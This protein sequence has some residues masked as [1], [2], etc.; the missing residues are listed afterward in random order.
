M[1]FRGRCPFKM[2]LPS[3]P[4]KY[5]IKIILICDN[6]TKY[7]FNADVYLG[8]GHHN[9]DRT[10][11]L[12]QHFT[13]KLISPLMNSNRN[14]TCDNWFSSVELAETLLDYKITM[15]GT[16]RKNK[17]YFPDEFTNPLY[18]RR[19]PGSSMFLFSEK[20]TAVS[21][22]PN[23]K[24]KVV[25]LIST[26][27][28]DDSINS[29]SGKPEIILNYNDAKG[30][31]DTFDQLC[32]NMNCG[33][34]TR[35]WPMCFF[36]NLINMALHNAYVIYVHNHYKNNKEIKALSRFDF[37]MQLADELSS[38]W[39]HLRLSQQIPRSLKLTISKCLKIDSEIVPEKNTIFGQRR[40]CF[41]CPYKKRRM[42][43]SICSSCRNSICGEHQIKVCTQCVAK[44]T[45]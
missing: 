23:N 13:V 40:I 38:S 27:H 29:K 5:G 3:K 12:A 44:M 30:S 25:C 9:I 4:N 20:I 15:I 11:S 41:Q 24:K 8:K 7:M 33:R 17:P 22:K 6:S 21:Y 39:M 2:Y 37:C 19:P 16:I 42:T 43:K 35:R 32:Q 18:K 36:Y 45:P 1:G 31:V 28:S 26:M 10:K 34:K 14:L